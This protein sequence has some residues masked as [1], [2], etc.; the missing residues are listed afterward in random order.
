M[1]GPSWTLGSIPGSGAEG[2]ADD[3]PPLGITP[4][5]HG[6]HSSRRREAGSGGHTQNVAFTA[7]GAASGPGPRGAHPAGSPRPSV[8]APA[9]TCESCRGLGQPKSAELELKL[10]APR[11]LR[12][13]CGT[14][15]SRGS[16]GSWQ[17]T[18]IEEVS[19]R[20]PAAGQWPRPPPHLPARGSPQRGG[21]GESAR[22]GPAPPHRPRTP[23][24]AGPGRAGPRAFVRRRQSPAG[25][26]AGSEG[27]G[28]GGGR[29]SGTALRRP[30][31]RVPA[32]RPLLRPR[33]EPL[34]APAAGAAHGSEDE[35]DG[36]RARPYC[37]ARPAQ[38]EAPPHGPAPRREGAGPSARGPEEEEEREREEEREGGGLSL[39]PA[40]P[41]P[42][43]PRT[44][45]PRRRH[46]PGGRC[47]GRTAGDTQRVI[48]SLPA[49]PAPARPCAAAAAAAQGGSA[50][51]AGPARRVSAHAR[52]V[53][54]PR[55][56]EPAAIPRRA[57][58]GRA[59]L[60]RP[61]PWRSPLTGGRRGRACAPRA[62]AGPISAERGL[63][64][65]ARPAAG[66]GVTG[67]R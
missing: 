51:P 35:G 19:G 18:S 11:R 30:R 65:R 58:R 10:I 56:T 53:S 12:T 36:R 59:G 14:G 8:P 42:E 22:G 23:R 1:K 57:R 47:V 9:P 31:R 2:E 41:R 25:A 16:T 63:R 21:E 24:G 17:H 5:G 67:R 66:K 4:G 44:H 61:A 52:P 48:T 62:R 46:A 6:P 38:E 3:R 29:R 20:R 26:A 37:P 45:W 64:G 32:R 39:R 50:A 55:R 43:Q 15:L 40:R 49:R 28:E 7:G 33:R 60:P 13:C 54:R 27:R 34:S